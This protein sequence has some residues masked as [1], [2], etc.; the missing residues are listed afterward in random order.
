MAHLTT[1]YVRTSFWTLTQLPVSQTQNST[2]GVEAKA[3]TQPY[4]MKPPADPYIR[5]GSGC[6]SLL[7]SAS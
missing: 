6:L 3:S 1:G 7:L 2:A 5:I 4:P